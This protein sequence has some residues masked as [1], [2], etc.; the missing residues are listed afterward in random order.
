MIALQFYKI[1][2]CRALGLLSGS[3]AY[4]FLYAQ[5]FRKFFFLHFS[6]ADDVSFQ[7]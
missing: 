6:F 2:D 1:S 3:R 7:P 5:S 4:I